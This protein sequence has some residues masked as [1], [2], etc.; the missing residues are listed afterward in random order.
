M[1][2]GPRESTVQSLSTV[3]KGEGWGGAMVS[4]DPSTVFLDKLLFRTAG[5]EITPT[6]HSYSSGVCGGV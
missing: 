1:P 6:A 4:A 2:E 3:T 5:W